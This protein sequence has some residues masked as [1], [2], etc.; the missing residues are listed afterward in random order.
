MGYHLLAFFFLGLPI[1]SFDATTEQHQQR[2]VEKALDRELRAPCYEDPR[3]RK[4]YFR[5]KTHAHAIGSV[6]LKDL[7]E[8]YG[9]RRHFE[10]SLSQ[11]DYSKLYSCTHS[12]NCSLWSF[13]IIGTCYISAGMG[14]LGFV[15]IDVPGGKYRKITHLKWVE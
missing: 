2:L 3:G 4:Y 9:Q 6:T 5:G 13:E 14:V 10:E 11:D 12:K 8:H 1:V 15:L 7:D